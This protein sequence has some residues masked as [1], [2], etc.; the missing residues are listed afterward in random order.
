MTKSSLSPRQQWLLEALQRT[1][2]GRIEGLNV[3]NGEPVLSPSPRVIRD[4]KLG[5]PGNDSRP[6]LNTTDFALKREH[7]EL[8]ET[9]ARVGSGTIESIEIRHGLPFRIIF[10]DRR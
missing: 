9:L 4:V 6:E 3:C 7:V 1:P 5:T 8:F 10:E 2:F